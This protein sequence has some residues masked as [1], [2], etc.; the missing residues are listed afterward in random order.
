M[1]RRYLLALAVAAGVFAM[2]AHQRLSAAGNTGTIQG[3]VRLTGPA[4]G[5]PIIR[6]GVDPMCAAINAG[7]SRPVQQIVTRSA[8]GGLANV[9]VTL[10]GTFPRVPPPKTA[11]TIR[12]LKCVNVPRVVGVMVGQTLTI[13]NSD[14]LAHETH[15]ITSKG[16]SF[17]VTQP[18]SDM[19]FT[20]TPKAPEEM[21]RL[22]CEIHRWMVAWV[23]VEAHPYFNVTTDTGVFTIANVPAG[24]HQIKAWHERYGWQTKTVDV[25]PGA[26]ATV[27]FTYT[28]QERPAA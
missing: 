1:K 26:T 24:R 4:P 5:N 25:K 28:G 19:V 7:P 12:Q 20:Y 9:F 22:G 8:D 17:K 13:V 3:H 18:H 23:G 2:N 11:V 15:S 14:T 16:N 21:L 27:D 6:M 10:T